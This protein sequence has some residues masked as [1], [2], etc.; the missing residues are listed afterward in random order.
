MANPTGKGG[1]KE[2]KDHIWRGG[3][4]KGMHGL[5]ELARKIANETAMRDGRPIVV[6]KHQISNA[7][8]I[9]RQWALSGNY[10]KQLAFIEYAFGKLADKTEIGGIEGS[11]IEVRDVS[12]VIRKL[13]PDITEE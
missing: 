9:F 10:S 2:H 4:P 11:P 6:D 8:M 7:E 3:R 12:D 1:F 13:L 5:R